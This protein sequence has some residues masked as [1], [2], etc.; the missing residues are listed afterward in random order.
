MQLNFLEI[1]TLLGV[2]SLIYY[3]IVAPYKRYF[4]FRDRLAKNGIKHSGA[5]LNTDLEK[6]DYRSTYD[7][8]NE[9]LGEMNVLKNRLLFNGYLSFLK[10]PSKD[11]IDEAIKITAFMRNSLGQKRFIVDNFYNYE[12]LMKIFDINQKM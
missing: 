1:L 5:I 10:I 4:D 3:F 7:E 2:P 9:W 11:G 8:L 12:R 6:E